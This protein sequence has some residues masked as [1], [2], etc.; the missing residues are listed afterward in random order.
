MTNEN[1]WNTVTLSRL[2]NRTNGKDYI[3]NIFDR[4]MELHGDR[5]CGDDSAIICGIAMFE[6]IPVTVIAQNRGKSLEDAAAHNYAMAKPEG[7]RKAMRVMKE[8]EKFN[9]PIIVFVDTPGA[10]AGIE[11]EYHGQAS[12]IAYCLRMT[13]EL[14]VP[15]ISVLIGQGGS[16]GAIAL[17]LADRVYML[18]NAT[19][20]ILSPEEFANIL[21]KDTTKAREAAKVMGI[22]AQDLKRKDIIEDII[23]EDEKGIQENP[24]L[25]FDKLRIILQR[26][27]RELREIDA[28]ELV[29]RR[30]ERFRRY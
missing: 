21:Y 12:A 7:Y 4:F 25:S 23:E 2:P 28:D 3:D 30:Q 17:A 9:R 6:G 16:G 29:R 13:S 10:D 18:E 24:E 26:D 8:A 15:I 27:L 11:S 14:R 19:Y 1:V 22:T 5:C 20:S